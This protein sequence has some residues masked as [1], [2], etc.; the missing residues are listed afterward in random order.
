MPEVCF[1]HDHTTSVRNLKGKMMSQTHDVIYQN[2]LQKVRI[3]VILTKMARRGRGKS[4]GLSKIIS[5]NCYFFVTK[6]GAS[7]LQLN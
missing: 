2:D 4:Y 6:W 1:L 7:R 3:K 5:E